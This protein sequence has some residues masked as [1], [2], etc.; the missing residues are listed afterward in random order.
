M[1]NTQELSKLAELRARTDRQ[2]AEIARSTL[3]NG[4]IFAQAAGAQVAGADRTIGGQFLARAQWSCGQAELLLS[5][6][7]DPENALRKPLEQ[8]LDALKGRLDEAVRARQ[9]AW[10]TAYC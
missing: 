5:M 7:R 2:L 6:L 8:K 10:M 1:S 9:N 4:L 3:E